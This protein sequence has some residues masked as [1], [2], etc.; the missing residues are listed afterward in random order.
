[1]PLRSA[2]PLKNGY[3]PK[4]GP[5]SVTI[6]LDFSSGQFLF[7]DLTAE[8]QQETISVV[9]CV[10]IDNSN[11]PYPV[12]LFFAITQFTLWC[13]P[14]CQGFFPI[15]NSGPPNFTAFSSGGV[16]ILIQL[17]NFP[18]P[19][20]VWGKD[21]VPISGSVSISGTVSTQPESSA[22]TDLSGT[23]TGSAVTI[24][25]AGSRKRVLI[26]NPSTASASLFFDF[27]KTAVNTGLSGELLPGGIF[28]SGAGPCPD[29]A[30]SVFAAS[31]QNYNAWKM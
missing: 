3:V 6:P 1:M 29:G 15:V 31:S 24:D 7:E 22:V 27:A 2:F 8:S 25:A 21:G 17:L 30:L 5:Q 13:P 12:S 23:G 20:A 11:N 26:E 14:N 19:A 4:E 28:D 16:K 18:M 10:F 9:Q